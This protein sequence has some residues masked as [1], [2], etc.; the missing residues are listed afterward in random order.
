MYR[1]GANEKR[2][3]DVAMDDTMTGFLCSEKEYE[4]SPI[5][6]PTPRVERR[7]PVQS[8]RLTRELHGVGEVRAAR[9]ASLA[10]PS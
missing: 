7:S 3:S 10:V 4:A 5:E 8:R 6:W 9:H 2:T 1:S